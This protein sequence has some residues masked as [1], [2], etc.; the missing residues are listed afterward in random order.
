MIAR[1]FL[2]AALLALAGHASASAPAH[3]Q[4]EFGPTLSEIHKRGRVNCGVTE[5]PGFAERTPSGD[6]RGFDADFCRAVAAAIFDDPAKVGFTPLAAKDRTPALQAGWVDFLASA[7]PWTESR[8]A[9]QR[10]IYAGVSFYDGQSFLVPSA[11][12]LGSAQDLA[13]VSVC[14]QQAS[15]YELTLADFFRARKTPYEPRLFPTQEE[16]AKAYENGQCDVL[17]ADASALHAIRAK[18]PA[19]AAHTVLAD[20]LSK[21][22][23]GLVLRQGDDQWFNVLR[24]TL[25]VMIGAEE[26]QLSKSSADEALRSENPEIRRFFGVEGDRGAGLGLAGDWTYRVIKHVGS[27]ADVFDR[28]LGQGSP[29]AMD[30]RINAL[31]NKGGLMFA[32]PVR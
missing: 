8:D 19:P 5:A 1:R 30:R 12:S 31:W 13:N 27:Y 22:P 29:L 3:A 32:P 18:L 15:S 17:T 24:W 9:G 4:S 20:H 26:L 28:N 10:V 7:A 2:T 25:Y 11:R 23:H 21:A 14:V 16:A 6:W